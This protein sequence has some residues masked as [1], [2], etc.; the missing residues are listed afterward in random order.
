MTKQEAI[1]TLTEHCGAATRITVTREIFELATG[2]L[3]SGCDYVDVACE[4]LMSLMHG[5]NDA[6][7]Q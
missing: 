2:E 7:L 6:E 1:D 5:G 3:M 4:K